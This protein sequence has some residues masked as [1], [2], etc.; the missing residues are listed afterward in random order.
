MTEA[1][2]DR[3]SGLV[4]LYSERGAR[5]IAE[6]HVVVVGLGGVGSWAAEA[7]ARS[8]IG[9]L[10]LVDLDDVCVTNINRQV[11]AVSD[12]VGQSK[13]Q[14]MAVR[15]ARIHPECSVQLRA[16]FFTEATAGA[17][18]AGKIDHVVDAIDDVPNKCL[19]IA[20]CR[21]GG[22][23]VVV[24][25][26]AGG[27]RDATALRVE[28]LGRTSHDRLLLKVRERLRREHGFPAGGKRFGVAAVY[29]MEPPVFPW[30]NG[31]VC[32][33]QEPGS[34]ARLTCDSGF[35]TAAFVT[36]AFGF[37]AAAEAVRWIAT[38]AP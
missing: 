21:E 38:R 12:T 25:G 18:L 19:L 36:G 20:R 9:R 15:I 28:D 23:P 8:G 1:F 35:G 6:S 7:L 26:G 34:E 5:R 14:A 33:A 27:K 11:Q 24:C 2:N 13:V 3:F 37:A 17:I 4:R 31:E 16:E 10:T 22:I 30:A 29:S 32:D